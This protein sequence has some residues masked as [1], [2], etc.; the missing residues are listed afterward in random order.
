[1]AILFYVLGVLS[2]AGGGY[3]FYTVINI[4]KQ[5]PVDTAQVLAF[6]T[7]TPALILVVAGLLFVAVGAALAR[8]DR[9]VRNTSKV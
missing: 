7:I 4:L 1:M 8:L 2:L 6:A 5:G 9:I 3:M